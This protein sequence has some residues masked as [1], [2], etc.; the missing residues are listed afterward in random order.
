MTPE[1][2]EHIRREN[3]ERY[4][5]ENLRAGWVS[6]LIK[7]VDRLNASIARI[8]CPY[9]GDTDRCHFSEPCELC[10]LAGRPGCY[11]EEEE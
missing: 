9:G 10:D 3:K 4:L 8:E 11:G 7:E 1:R 5:T 2:L 6:E